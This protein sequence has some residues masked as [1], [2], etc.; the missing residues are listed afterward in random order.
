MFCLQ[1]TQRGGFFEY[2]VLSDDS[3]LVPE[4]GSCG[5]SSIEEESKSH[6]KQSSS[7]GIQQQ[8]H[9]NE[10]PEPQQR[11]PRTPRGSRAKHGRKTKRKSTV[12]PKCI[13]YATVEYYQEYFEIK[14]FQMQR[15]PLPIPASNLELFVFDTNYLELNIP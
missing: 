4:E 7:F 11:T 15:S 13:D 9:T 10:Y 5:E 2:V 14:A 8:H 12:I 3:Y 6:T 1:L